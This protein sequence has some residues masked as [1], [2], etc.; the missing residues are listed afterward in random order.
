MHCDVLILYK[1]REKRFKI[2]L[3]SV[4]YKRKRGKC[5]ERANAK[6]IQKKD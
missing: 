5:N 1:G 4:F 3:F 2:N 6:I